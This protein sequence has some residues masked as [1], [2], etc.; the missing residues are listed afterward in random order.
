[1]K[2]KRFI[3]ADIRQAIKKVR[4][5][6]GPEAVILSNR[7]VEGGVEIVSAIDYD[8]ALVNGFNAPITAAAPVAKAV[9]KQAPAFGYKA[10]IAQ[11]I[12]PSAERETAA[13]DGFKSTTS[14][15]VN[16][17]HTDTSER[18]FE[19]QHPN[20]LLEMR[21]E[22][23]TLR[24]LLENQLSGFAWGDLQKRSPIHAEL[25]KRLVKLGLGV[26]LCQEIGT[27][28]IAT[29]DIEQGW[30]QALRSLERKIAITNDDILSEG[31]VVALVGPTGVGKTTTIAKLAA[32]YALRYG[33]RHVALITLDNYRI[34]AYEQ[35]RAYG[36]ILDV[37]VRLVAKEDELSRIVDEYGDRRLI[38]IDTAGM[39]HRDVRLP[40]QLL[41]L[42]GTKNRVSCH[43]VL[44]TTTRLSLLEEVVSVYKEIELTSC[45]L[46]KLDETT[47]LGSA[48]STVI[49]HQL[50][51]SYF[52]DG[53]RVPEDIHTARA[54]M[55]VQRSVA[56]M[57]ENDRLLDGEQFPYTIE[58]AVADAH[59]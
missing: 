19:A 46:T 22:L 33:S 54:D 13:A 6:L 29:G 18:A 31:G 56:I 30:Q 4:E 26:D 8:E 50:P 41:M 23:R 44:S 20:T 32:R 14:P 25:V 3:A 45:I 27:K 28:L 11:R 49:H 2:I 36:R 42:R 5:E 24:G 43:L 15:Q 12:T 47:S 38:L 34:G 17:S 55:L 35:L 51:I 53:Q 21:S 57:K 16:G 40:Q 52:S 37:P 10:P 48:I 7:R 1:M 39:S 58:R 9:V 59:A